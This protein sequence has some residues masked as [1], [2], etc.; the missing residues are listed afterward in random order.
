[1]AASA[2]ALGLIA[3]PLASTI[4]SAAASDDTGTEGVSH[5]ADAIHQEIV[6]QAALERVYAALTDA[7]Q[8]DKVIDLSG[9][10][11]AGALPPE[12]NKPTQVSPEAGGAFVLFGGSSRPADRTR[13]KRPSRPSL[14]QANWD[15]GIYSIARFELVKQGARDQDR[16]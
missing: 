12:A 11:Q 6:F 14:A 13:A 4:G 16:L 15:P 5:T 3:G 9:I 8:F 1:M 10:R 7:K 2:P